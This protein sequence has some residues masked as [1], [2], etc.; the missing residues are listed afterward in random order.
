ML[1]TT[2]ASARAQEGL[3]DSHHIWR[4]AAYWHAR[5]PDWV[6]RYHPDWAV[7]HGWWESDHL[8]H[9][10]WFQ[11]SF[12]HAYPLWTYGAYDQYRVWRSAQWWHSHDPAWLY[13]HHPEWAAPYSHWVR[14]D[15][16][17]HPEWFRSAYWHDHPYSLNHPYER[18]GDS[19]A[20]HYDQFSGET[21]H[22]GHYQP[23]GQAASYRHEETWRAPTAARSY[24][25]SAIQSHS[26]VGSSNAGHKYP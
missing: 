3:Y 26:A 25:N 19:H 23:T 22:N 6:Y 8:H 5:H 1:I 13:A 18:Y 16:G 7:S 14:E 17:Q 15:Y 10:E 21:W 24:N 4:D 2:Q 9:P 12:W 20:P 11:S